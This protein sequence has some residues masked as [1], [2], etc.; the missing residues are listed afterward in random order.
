MNTSPYVIER[1][2]VSFWERRYA[3]D[4][5]EAFYAGLFYND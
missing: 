3:L 5:V 1:A 2:A 4:A